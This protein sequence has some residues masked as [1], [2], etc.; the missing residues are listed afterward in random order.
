MDVG[1]PQQVPLPLLPLTR[2]RE[3][4]GLD[5]TPCRRHQQGPREVGGRL[6]ED[7]RGVGDDDPPA[8]RRGDVDV[9]V[10]DSDVRDDL[11]RGRGGQ[12]LLVDRADDVADEPV[13]TP[14]PGNQFGL[15][16]PGLRAVVVDGHVPG[17]EL[18]GLAG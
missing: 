7:V 18:A 12:D 5:D 9:V 4:V 15:G 1:A 11:H 14:K 8:A 16:Q 3:V 13:L 17:N 10:A 6:G 2:A